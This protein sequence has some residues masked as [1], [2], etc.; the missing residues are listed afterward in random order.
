MT[1]LST[2]A[3]TTLAVLVISSVPLLGRQEP[4]LAFES[5]LEAKFLPINAGF[6]NRFG[7]AVAIEAGV[8]V[9]GA[10]RADVPGGPNNAGSVFVYRYDGA[11]WSLEQRL[12]SSNIAEDNG[13]GHST[14]IS[15]D[16]IVIGAPRRSCG[17]GQP[18]STYSFA[19]VAGTWIQQ[20]EL[21]V[22]SLPSDDHF[23]ESVALE[24]ATLVVYAPQCSSH[25]AAYVYTSNG[26]M[27]DSQQL[28]S[29]NDGIAGDR[30]GSSVG[31]DGAWLVVGAAYA[32]HPF[33]SSQHG[34]VDWFQWDGSSWVLRRKLFTTNNNDTAQLGWTSALS[35]ERAILGC[36]RYGLIGSQSGAALS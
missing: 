12:H 8:V 21:F 30:F 15:G 20:Q 18:G 14:C 28:L 34:A 29:A 24:V 13:F 36:D 35:G 33:G 6:C 9:V 10:E 31:V 19:R 1:I 5:Q 16:R 17:P 3:P 11:Q 22:N 2:Q 26:S 32:D 23:G 25:G 7:Y 27:W 4:C